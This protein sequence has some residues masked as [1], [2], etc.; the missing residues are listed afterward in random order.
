MYS[1]LHDKIN[2]QNQANNGQNQSTKSIN[3]YV[4]YAKC[5][6]NQTTKS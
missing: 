5:G 6:Q 2:R 4:V 3:E 1:V